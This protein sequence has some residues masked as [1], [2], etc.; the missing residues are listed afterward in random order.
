MSERLLGPVSAAVPTPG[1]G[2][3]PQALSWCVLYEFSLRLSLQ[4]A[5]RH[6]AQKR[7]CNCTNTKSWT[8]ESK[9]GYDAKGVR[10]RAGRWAVLQCGASDKRGSSVNQCWHQCV[11]A[12]PEPN[13]LWPMCSLH[14]QPGF[15]LRTL[16]GVAQPSNLSYSR[17]F[18]SLCLPMPVELP[19]AP[20]GNTSL[21][22][23]F[24]AVPGTAAAAQ[25]ET[26][27]DCVGGGV[28]ESYLHGQS[29]DGTGER[30]SPRL[31][32]LWLTKRANLK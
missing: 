17:A 1:H 31:A 21:A 19:G 20:G 16:E 23:R 27:W 26:V 24:A 28:R 12:S 30:C 18:P 4:A 29:V 5:S 15:R 8:R 25:G 32:G 7:S 22:S 6:A 10:P 9:M 11:W 13:C 14:S 3:L 2:T